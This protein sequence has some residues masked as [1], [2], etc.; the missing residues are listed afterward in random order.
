MADTNTI[1]T[2]EMYDE[3]VTQLIAEK[4]IADVPN[5]VMEQLKEDLLTRLN[6]YFNTRV[7]AVMN[8]EQLTG[9]NDLLDKKPTSEEIQQYV[10]T[11]IPDQSEFIAGTLLEFRRVYLGLS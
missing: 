5:E 10:A 8:D 3:F 11:V 1:K 7:I 9:F 6:D 2:P 4:G